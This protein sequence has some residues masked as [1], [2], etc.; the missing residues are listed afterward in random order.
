MNTPGDQFCLLD[1]LN[2]TLN[3]EYRF[4]TYILIPKSR[5]GPKSIGAKEDWYTIGLF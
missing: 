3:I 5:L 1:C 4:E 2:A